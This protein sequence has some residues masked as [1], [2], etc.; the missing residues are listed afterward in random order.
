MGSCGSVDASRQADPTTR[1]LSG[2]E[3]TED[4][5]VTTFSNE[6]Y[7]QWTLRLSRCRDNANPSVWPWQDRPSSACANS[8]IGPDSVGVQQPDGA[9]RR[10]VGSHALLR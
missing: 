7:G 3:D 8:D 1:S 5:R 2:V 9:D 6:P 10:I 4:P